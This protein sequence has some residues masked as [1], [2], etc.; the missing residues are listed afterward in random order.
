MGLTNDGWYGY[1]LERGTKHIKKNPFI[2]RAAN[3]A[4]P[5]AKEN[6]GKDIKTVIVNNGR[7]LGLD[8]K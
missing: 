1:F 7:R 6:L 4:I 3:P 5:A 8:I 2:N